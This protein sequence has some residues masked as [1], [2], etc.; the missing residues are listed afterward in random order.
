M[1]AL[2]SIIT[3][4][5]MGFFASLSINETQLDNI[6]CNY[7]E[8]FYCHV[9]CHLAL[10]HY[11]DCRG[12]VNICALEKRSS[13]FPNSVNDDGKTFYEFDVTWSRQVVIDVVL[14]SVLSNFFFDAEAK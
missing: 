3:L 9:K 4:S 8:W 13:L 14:T 12:A 5:I 10:W 6:E 2:T 1:C 7:D 11:V